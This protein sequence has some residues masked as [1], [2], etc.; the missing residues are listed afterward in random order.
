MWHR[1]FLFSWST[2]VSPRTIWSIYPALKTRPGLHIWSITAMSLV[3]LWTVS[4]WCWTGFPFHLRVS[5][6]SVSLTGHLHNCN[7]I[8]L[9][10]FSSRSVVQCGRSIVSITGKKCTQNPCNACNTIIVCL[11]VFFFV[12]QRQSKISDIIGGVRNNNRVARAATLLALS[13]PCLQW[14]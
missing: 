5:Q 14:C 3:D 9:A 12:C 13:A 4:F 2:G 10:I 7:L 8:Y 6:N 1:C 11:F